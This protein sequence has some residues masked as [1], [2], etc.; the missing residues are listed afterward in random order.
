MESTRK[1]NGID[2]KT[3]RLA[4]S[5]VATLKERGIDLED[6]ETKL[7]LKDIP[8][9]LLSAVRKALATSKIPALLSL[10]EDYEESDEPLVVF[11]D[12]RAPVEVFEGR[13]G[14]ATITGSTSPENRH[15]AVERFQAGEL[16]GIA[17]TIKAMGIGLTLTRAHHVILNDLNWTPALNAQAEDRLCRIGQTRGV[18]V[19]RLVANH[20]L[21]RRITEL[22]VEKQKVIEASVEAS[23]VEEGYV[24]NNP[25]EALVQAAERAKQ[26]VIDTAATAQQERDQK[27]Q[28]ATEDKAAVT[29]ELAAAGIETDGREIEIRGR[30]RSAANATEEWAGKG[31]VKVADLDPDRAAERNA[32]G[33]SAYDGEF[34]HSLARQYQESGRFTAKQWKAA[35]KLATRYRRQI[36]PAPEAK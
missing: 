15:D 32:V 4:D 28:R 2:A 33:F 26:Q 16:K 22:L 1:T 25:A 8:F 13:D 34:G 3:R 36:G 21:E 5:I 10:V 27:A 17:G 6:A 35:I 29:A 23:A 7:N 12:H 24:G 9:E 31:L 19:T 18:I 30:T 14:W 11:S 20:P